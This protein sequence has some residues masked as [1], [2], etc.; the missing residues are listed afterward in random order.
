MGFSESWYA[1]KGKSPPSVSW[2]HICITPKPGCIGYFVIH[3]EKEGRTTKV[4]EK[5]F[6]NR[7][8]WDNGFPAYNLLEE[9]SNNE[10]FVKLADMVR[11]ANGNGQHKGAVGRKIQCKGTTNS[12]ERCKAF[13]KKG[14]DKCSF[15]QEED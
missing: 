10:Q 3:E 7:I 11:K 2:Y 14:S 9:L 15:H 1:L 12:G 6:S 8:P 13:R 5:V 4:A